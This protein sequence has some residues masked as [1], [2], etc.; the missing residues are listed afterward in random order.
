MISYV[1]HYILG[2]K[3]LESLESMVKLSSYDINN[4]RLG[5]LIVDYYSNDCY[6]RFWVKKRKTHFF[7]DNSNMGLGL[8]IDLDNFLRKYGKIVSSDFSALGCLFH[9]YSDKVFLKLLNDNGNDCSY[10]EGM[11]WELFFND[12]ESLDGFFDY[13]K[14]SFDGSKLK[15][16]AVDNFI[17]PG[18]SEVDYFKIYDVIERLDEYI[19]VRE[20]EQ[21]KDLGVLVFK[22]FA[23]SDV[24]SFIVDGFWRF[25]DNEI[26]GTVSNA[27]FSR[28]R[29]L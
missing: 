1:I 12:K 18:I 17:N 11:N 29:G 8:E 21:I 3:F 28:R 2:E 25:Y 15:F 20:S 4:F 16:F 10:V 5:N 23:F 7:S 14:R 22:D 19:L 13:F 6:D 26:C 24:I 27:C 9:L